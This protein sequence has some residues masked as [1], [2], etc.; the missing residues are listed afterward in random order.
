LS[1][2]HRGKRI[3]AGIRGRCS[4]RMNTNEILALTRD[5]RRFRTNFPTLRLISPP[6]R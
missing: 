6:L 2:G 5:V 3:V 4:V 1:S